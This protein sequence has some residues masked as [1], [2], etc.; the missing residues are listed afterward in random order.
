MEEARGPDTKTAT[1]YK[2]EDYTLPSDPQTSTNR[3]NKRTVQIPNSQQ[4]SSRRVL[5]QAVTL[6]QKELELGS[7]CSVLPRTDGTS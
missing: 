2:G 5:L 3:Q 1:A 6:L 7:F 4:S